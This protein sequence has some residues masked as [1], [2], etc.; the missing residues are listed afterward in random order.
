M[1]G[2]SIS[3]SDV[4]RPGKATRMMMRAIFLSAF[5]VALA[6]CGEQRSVEDAVREVMKDPKSAEFRRIQVCKSDPKVWV[7]E[8]NAK[9]SYGAYEGFTV[10]FYDGD[11]VYLPDHPRFEGAGS[12]CLGIDGLPLVR[13]LVEGRE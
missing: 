10:F 1:F 9:N 13:S 11:E 6:S 7:G 8:V 2:E 5:M 4:A 12:R 3:M